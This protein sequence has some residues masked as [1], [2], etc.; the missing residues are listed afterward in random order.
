[1]ALCPRGKKR[2]TR[3]AVYKTRKKGRMACSFGAS[4]GSGAR[5]HRPIEVARLMGVEGCH[6][7]WTLRPPRAGCFGQKASCAARLLQ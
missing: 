7:R 4:A 6:L 3:A 5:Q 1:M 2:G